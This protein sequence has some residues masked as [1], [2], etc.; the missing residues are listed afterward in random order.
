MLL[1]ATNSISSRRTSIVYYG[2]ISLKNNIRNI[3]LLINLLNGKIMQ[4][5]MP[6]YCSV[7]IGLRNNSKDLKF[8]SDNIK[9]NVENINAYLII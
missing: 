6:Q 5:L 1:Y 7:I 2:Q 3:F 8:I 4:K 9:Q